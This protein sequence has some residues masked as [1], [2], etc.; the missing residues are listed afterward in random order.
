MK[1]ILQR[2]Q[3]LQKYANTYPLPYFPYSPIT[4]KKTPLLFSNS[5]FLSRA[6]ARKVAPRPAA[7]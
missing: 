5:S 1:P 2:E 3:R 6:W 7:L 4:G